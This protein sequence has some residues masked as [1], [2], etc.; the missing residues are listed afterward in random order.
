MCWYFELPNGRSPDIVIG[1]PGG[2]KPLHILL[3]LLPNPLEYIELNYQL[4]P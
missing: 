1:R 2:S 3:I 4:P